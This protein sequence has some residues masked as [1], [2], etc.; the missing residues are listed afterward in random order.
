MPKTEKYSK[1]WEK[2]PRTHLPDVPIP[3]EEVS[4]MSCF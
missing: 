4:C 2:K 3:H 1:V